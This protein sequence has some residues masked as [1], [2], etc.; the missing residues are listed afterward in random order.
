MGETPKKQGTGA[1]AEAH[2]TA[3]LGL[4]T[5]LGSG[6]PIFLSSVEGRVVDALRDSATHVFVDKDLVPESAPRGSSITLTGVE[7]GF[8]QER[9]KVLIDIATPYYQ[10]KVWAV[11][12][13]RPIQNLLIGNHIETETGETLAVS[14]DLPEGVSAAVTTRAGAKE[15]GTSTLKPVLEPFPEGVTLKVSRADLV[16]LQAK[17][18]TLTSVREKVGRPS[19]TGETVKYTLKNGLLYRV[20]ARGK[21]QHTQVVVPKGLRETVLRMGHDM[22]MA[23][24]LGTKRTLERILHN[25]YWPGINTSVRQYCRTC[26]SCQRTTQKGRLSRVP[27]GSVP[28]VHEPFAKVG[29]DLVGP[30]KPVSRSGN[31]YILVIVDYATRYPEAIPLKHIDAETVAE[32][33]WEVWTH[34]GVPKEILT[35]MGTQFVSDLMKQVHKLLGTKPRTTTPY[36]AQANGLVERFNATLKQMLKRLC[37]D[38]PKDWDRYIPAVLFAY[39]EVPQESMRFSPFELLYGRTVQGPMSV[40]K[41]IW[42]KEVE[43]DTPERSEVQYVLD[44][45]ER[46]ASTCEVA[47]RNLSTAKKR[48]AK[49]FNKKTRERWFEPGDEVLLL[50]PEKK[51]KLQIAWRGPYKVLERVCDWDYRIKVGNKERLYHAN[52]LKE[53]HRREDPSSA[54]V[55]SAGVSPVVVDEDDLQTQDPHSGLENWELRLDVS[56]LRRSHEPLL[57]VVV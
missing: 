49:H 35:D 41:R 36:H 12:L 9:Q 40:L 26:D 4:Q 52:L 44:L 34:V 7:K 43:G 54:A 45:R 14:T 2:D 42:T 29:V 37:I 48:Y 16:R 31:R 46:L 47:Q 51:N 55:C 3:A 8:R 21:E 23:G 11:A 33:L 10:G 20:Y 32:A 22:P 53:Y 24:H 18:P 56:T 17:D 6:L 25:F 50:L 28:L 1:I 5:Q 38:H 15:T 39:R 57:R 13:E 19:R 27:L 30:I